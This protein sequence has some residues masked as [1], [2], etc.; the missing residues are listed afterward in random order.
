RV[1]IPRH[2]LAPG[3]YD[4][5][6]GDLLGGQPPGGVLEHPVKRLKRPFDR[7][8]MLGTVTGQPH[9]HRDTIFP[10]IDCV[11]TLIENVHVASPFLPL[12]RE[13]ARRLRNPQYERGGWYSRS[14]AQPGTPEPGG[15]PAPI[16]ATAS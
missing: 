4:R 2:R 3:V 13:G 5:H 9:R 10:D 1:F 7:L 14:Q 11:T 8:P 15:A 6:M 12:N 16:S